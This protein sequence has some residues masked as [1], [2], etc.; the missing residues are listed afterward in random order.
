MVMEQVMYSICEPFIVNQ[1]DFVMHCERFDPRQGVVNSGERVLEHG[2]V[3]QVRDQVAYTL[4]HL[5]V[6]D[7]CL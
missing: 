7:V 1:V 2:K 3:G 6:P 5:T 4:Q